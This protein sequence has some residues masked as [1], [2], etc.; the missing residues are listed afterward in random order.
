MAKKNPNDE[1]KT[2]TQD[3]AVQAET[4]QTE[5]QGETVQT[6]TSGVNDVVVVG[7]GE[8]IEPTHYAVTL[9]AIHP[10]ATYG[11][12]GYRFSKESAGEIPAGDLTVEQIVTLAEDPWLEFVPVCDK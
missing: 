6:E 8:V 11:R 3:E 12:C 1:T 9:R 7:G 5:A 4:V 10:Q 2:E